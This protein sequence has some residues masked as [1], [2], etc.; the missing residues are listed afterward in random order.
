MWI[1]HGYVVDKSPWLCDKVPR[2]RRR[3]LPLWGGL[4]GNVRYPG[5][6]EDQDLL[7]SLG[8]M[9]MWISLGQVLDKSWTCNG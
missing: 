5:I 4:G 1:S 6:Q 8:Y 3:L 9:D 7:A 2:C